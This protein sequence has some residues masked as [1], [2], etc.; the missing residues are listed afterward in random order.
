MRM[1]WMLA[2]THGTPFNYVLRVHD[3][4]VAKVAKG[5]RPFTG[6]S[7]NYGCYEPGTVVS[8]EA[9][10][11]KD[12]QAFVQWTCDN[13]AIADASSPTTT[14]TTANQDQ[15]IRAIYADQSSKLVVNG[16]LA[17]PAAP[18]PGEVVSVTADA[19]TDESQFAY[20]KTDTNS[21]RIANPVARSF[22]FV[23]P[24]KSVTL[25]TETKDNLPKRRGR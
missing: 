14:F 3:G 5:E 4:V 22:R 13:G 1:S 11:V 25:A 9:P 24:A 19:D 8:I 21:I 18:M 16:G 12:G 2:Q 10:A 7:K 15:V 6:D 23:M 17:T 20:W